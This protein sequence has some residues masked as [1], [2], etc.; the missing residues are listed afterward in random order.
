MRHHGDVLLASPL[1]SCQ[2]KKALPNAQ[3][4][5]FLYL[6]TLAMLDGHLHFQFFALR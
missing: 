4:D 6:D 1:L 2:K 5:V 3:I